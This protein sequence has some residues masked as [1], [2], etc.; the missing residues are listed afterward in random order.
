MS[1]AAP[2]AAVDAAPVA[3]PATA[4]AASVA[5]PA[6]EAVVPAVA[7]KP[8]PAETPAPAPVAAT[9]TPP[10]AEIDAATIPLPAKA[11]SASEK[12]A[13][14]EPV[15]EKV[16]E[17][18]ESSPA[19]DASKPEEKPVAAEDKPAE[20]ANEEAAAAPV[21]AAPAPKPAT[22]DELDI[23]V[24]SEPA[25]PVAAKE[26]AKQAAAPKRAAK[27]LTGDELLGD[28]FDAMGDL[29]FLAS[30]LEGANFVV[31]LAMEKIPCSVGVCHFF[32]I[33]RRE[34]LVSRA[35]GNTEE[36]LLS[37]TP[38]REGLAAEVMNKRRAIVIADATTHEKPLPHWSRLGT[39]VKSA[40]VAPVALGGRWMGML[41]LVNPTDG[42]P[43]LEGDGY[44]LSYM[45]EQFAEFLGQRGLVNDPDVIRAFRPVR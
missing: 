28:L 7:E 25:P 43:F 24:A 3:A 41:E 37:R 33:D 35:L 10:P 8:A 4:P 29:Y 30:T 44:A 42:K 1:A 32:D 6:A 22:A 9:P 18:D 31:S 14:D 5:A 19:T 20:K 23:A 45:A 34:F 26:P 17:T 13:K 39:E 36:L 16:K 21:A 40:V 11:D 38:A 2:S 15:D 12:V 27:R